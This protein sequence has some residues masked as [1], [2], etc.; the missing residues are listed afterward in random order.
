MSIPTR[1]PK[2]RILS[3]RSLALTLDGKER[4]Y[5]V[6]HF[7]GRDF[8]EHPRHS[9]FTT[10]ESNGY[11]LHSGGGRMMFADGALVDHS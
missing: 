11:M 4:D 2:T 1:P 10:I 3:G 7:T 9:P 8:F 5:P 6:Y